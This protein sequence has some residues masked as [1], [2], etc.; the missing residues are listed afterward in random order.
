MK[1]LTKMI[2]A[3]A[4]SATALLATPA[5]AAESTCY[6]NKAHVGGCK[7]GVVKSNDLHHYIHI[8]TSRWVKYSLTDAKNNKV[9]ASG[10]S[11]WSTVS[12]T[13]TGLYGRYFG[14]ISGKGLSGKIRIHNS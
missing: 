6:I 2:S 7:T 8:D 5:F 14:K 13:V 9:V 1:T 3:F 12:R 11:G 4:L 10:N